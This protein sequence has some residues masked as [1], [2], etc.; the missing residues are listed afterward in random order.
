[1]RFSFFLK[2]DKGLEY[3]FDLGTKKRNEYLGQDPF[4]EFSAQA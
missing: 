1:M 3:M 2:R 4:K